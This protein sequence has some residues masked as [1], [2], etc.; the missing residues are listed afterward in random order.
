MFYLNFSKLGLFLISVFSCF[1][2]QQDAFSVPVTYTNLNYTPNMK[3]T[4]E[5]A[6]IEGQI[7]GLMQIQ[8][9]LNGLPNYFNQSALGQFVN[10]AAGFVDNVES[11]VT[12]T[13]DAAIG[14]ATTIAGAATDKAVGAVS[15]VVD[16]ATETVGGWAE[17]GADYVGDMFSSKDGDEKPGSG[18]VSNASKRD[19]LIG[20]INELNPIDRLT[21]REKDEKIC[22][23]L[24]T[25]D[26]VKTCFYIDNDQNPGVMEIGDTHAHVSKAQF[27]SISNLYADSAAV[28]NATAQFEEV[29]EDANNETPQ[30]V[31]QALTKRAET[32]LI[33]NVA[34]TA[35]LGLDLSTLELNSLSI[36]STINSVKS[37]GGF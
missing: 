19:D 29:E 34:S 36:Y 25:I 17:Q 27:A 14:S 21:T 6:T 20:K 1:S 7:N 22:D 24:G 11:T 23:G 9:S 10:K 32:D 30:T 26:G 2:F 13:V 35:Y 28:V 3:A 8:N 33:F 31:S 5:H 12:G 15:G 4:V 16:S 37:N 18:F